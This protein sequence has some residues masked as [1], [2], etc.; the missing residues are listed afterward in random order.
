MS[1]R[2]FYHITGRNAAQKKRAQYL[3]EHDAPLVGR[4]PPQQDRIEFINSTT[5]SKKTCSFE[6]LIRHVV[7]K[8]KHYTA[9]T[10]HYDSRYRQLKMKLYRG[11]DL[12]IDSSLTYDYL[13]KQ[14]ALEEA[15]RRF[16]VGSLKH[17]HAPYNSR[18]Y[19]A[20]LQDAVN[21]NFDPFLSNGF[22]VPPQIVDAHLEHQGKKNHKL[23]QW[24][25][26]CVIIQCILIYQSIL[27]TPTRL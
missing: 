1:N 25:R 27:E 15:C 3:K 26:V 13:G 16:T 21:P 11:N 8:L 2:E 17:N 18:K 7:F 14:Q 20:I 19:A 10:T 22:N 5:P 24:R 9:I 23:S 6:G 12:L 4:A